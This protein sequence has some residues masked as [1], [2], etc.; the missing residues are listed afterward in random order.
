MFSKEGPKPW[1]TKPGGS[2]LDAE[3]EAV[4]ARKERRDEYYVPSGAVGEEEEGTAGVANGE[5]RH[6]EGQAGTTNVE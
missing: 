6:V 2:R 3:I 4:I 1:L 5:T